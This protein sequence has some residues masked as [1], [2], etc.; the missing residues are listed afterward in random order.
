MKRFGF[1]TILFFPVFANSQTRVLTLEEAIATAMQNNYNIL[2]AKND[3]VSAAIDYS[4][5]NAAFI[6]RLNGN[7]GTVW[8]NNDQKQILSDG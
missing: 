1:L 6:P 5:K 4:Y 3:S 2:L 8:N 7:I